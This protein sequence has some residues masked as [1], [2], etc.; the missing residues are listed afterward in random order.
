MW[1]FTLHVLYELSIFKKIGCKEIHFPVM[2]QV[3]LNPC[4]SESSSGPMITNHARAEELLTM[5]FLPIR[6]LISRSYAVFDQPWWQSLERL[7]GLSHWW[8][9]GHLKQLTFV[10][11]PFPS[12][13]TFPLS[14]LPCHWFLPLFYLIGYVFLWPKLRPFY[15]R[16]GRPYMHRYTNMCTYTEM[17]TASVFKCI[18]RWIKLYLLL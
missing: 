13:L 1:S 4:I 16:R 2:I 11:K 12:C 15:S 7:F 9:V 3:T 10:S 14:C 18:S 17:H 8:Q 5:D 6:C